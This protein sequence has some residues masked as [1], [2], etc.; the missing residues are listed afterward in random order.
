MTELNMQFW[1][2]AIIGFMLCVAIYGGASYFAERTVRKKLARTKG[3]HDADYIV[4]E[5]ENIKKMDEAEKKSIEFT[6]DR[7][8]KPLHINTVL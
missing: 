5:R 3:K 7:M 6:S 4:R 1:I 8:T 2:G